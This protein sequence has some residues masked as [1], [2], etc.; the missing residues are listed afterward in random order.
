MFLNDN[1]DHLRS[2][3]ADLHLSNTDFQ[4][5]NWML[6]EMALLESTGAQRLLEV[7]CG[8]GIFAV[9][10]A[11]VFEQVYAIDW[12]ESPVIR[13]ELPA[14]RL[15]YIVGDALD[16]LLPSVDLS[17]SADFLE[18][19]PE[20]RMEDFIRKL[21]SSAPMQF[22]KIACYPDS[23]GLHLSIKSAEQWLRLF[24]SIDASFAILKREFRRNRQ[25]QEVVCIVR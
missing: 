10:A 8:N 7:G 14:P 13:S 23:R 6:G 24:Q 16:I 22:H 1:Q 11:N 21:S 19:I 15:E 20:D 18:H 5:N 17:V 12:V 4:R 25:D 2:I 3:Y 9:A